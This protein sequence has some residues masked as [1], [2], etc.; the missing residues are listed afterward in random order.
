MKLFLGTF[1]KSIP[2]RVDAFA[3]EIIFFIDALDNGYLFLCRHVSGHIDDSA[4]ASLTVW[5]MKTWKAMVCVFLVPGT[6]Y[7]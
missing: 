4:F 2:F 7:D 1:Q 5:N 3:M 6:T